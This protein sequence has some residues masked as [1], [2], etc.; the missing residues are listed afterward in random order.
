[1][2]GTADFEMSD[3]SPSFAADLSL[4]LSRLGDHYVKLD[5]TLV[6]AEA[7]FEAA[8][9]IA[10]YKSV[11][12]AAAAGTSPTTSGN[13]ATRQT[14]RKL[15]EAFAYAREGVMGLAP[16]AT[17]LAS[18]AASAFTTRRLR[19]RARVRASETHGFD[20]GAP[21]AARCA[22]DEGIAT[23]SMN[24]AEETALNTLIDDIRYGGQV[25]MNRI[26]QIAGGDRALFIF[27]LS[28]MHA[29]IDDGKAEAMIDAYEA[30]SAIGRKFG[31]IPRESCSVRVR[32]GNTIL[33]VLYAKR[34]VVLR[35]WVRE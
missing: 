18:E 3:M 16:A 32:A 24:A 14:R 20:R 19:Q 6:T 10:W 13:S 30:F 34:G 27:L 15:A 25:T 1:L 7:L 5:E 23:G 11:E 4:R 9:R 26:E 35:A 29:D 21:I 22:Y 31:K 33:R 12:V 2:I 17:D 8:Y 28:A